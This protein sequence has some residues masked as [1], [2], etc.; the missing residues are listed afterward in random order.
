MEEK[1]KEIAKVEILPEEEQIHD[2]EKS[3]L[4]LDLPE[5]ITI[6]PRS[7]KLPDAKKETKW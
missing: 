6:F 1:K 2:F 3:K 5:P 7:R 4:Y